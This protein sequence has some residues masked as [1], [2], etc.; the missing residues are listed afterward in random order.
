[1]E[2]LVIISAA[3]VVYYT[4]C[5]VMEA[6]DDMRRDGTAKLLQTRLAKVVPQL[7]PLS[8]PKGDGHRPRKNLYY[9]NFFMGGAQRPCPAFA[10]R[11]AWF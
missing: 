6:I 3:L 9:G 5:S 4:Y 8:I 2:P 7:Q 10:K 11:H 1:M